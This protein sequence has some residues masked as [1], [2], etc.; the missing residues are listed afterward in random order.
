MLKLTGVTKQFRATGFVLQPLSVNL[1]K[2]LHLFVGPNGAGKSTLLRMLA[3]V[4]RPDAGVIAWQ[5]RDIYADLRDYKF[6]LGYLPQTFGLYEDMTGREF[7]H[8]MAGLKGIAPGLG[9]ERADA[10]AG[11]IG[12]RQHC[13]RRIAFWS[14]G[15]RQCLGLAQALLNDPEILILDEPFDGLDSAE[16]ETVS[17]YLAYLAR[18]K[19]ILI[20]SH[21]LSELPIQG[22]LLF[23]D[24]I[25]RFSGP[26]TVLS[27]KPGVMSG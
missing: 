1:D 5:N 15:L 17:A 13:N 8:Y 4:L 21:L 20:S 23:S 18:D 24:G 10:V 2:G 3:T 14:R 25:L 6:S 26:S 11:R 12:I 27:T 22:L 7:L 16:I 9:K 19:V